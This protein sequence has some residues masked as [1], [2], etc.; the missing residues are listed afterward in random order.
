MKT[1]GKKLLKVVGI[2][3]VIFG[4]LGLLGTALNFFITSSMTPE[5]EEL[6]AQSGLF[7]FGC[8]SDGQQYLE[9]GQL[10]AVAACR[11]RRY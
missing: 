6:M 3:L 5:M 1:P 8:G 9:P 7:L 2:L 4:V 11:H 10:R